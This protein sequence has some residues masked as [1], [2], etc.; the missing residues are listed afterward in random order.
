V[1]VGVAGAVSKLDTQF[2][3]GFAKGRARM[4]RQEIEDHI[5]EITEQ[6]KGSMPDAARQLLYLDRKDLRAKLAEIEAYA[7]DG[8]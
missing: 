1:A 6:M 3:P 8:V 7:K 2:I 5:A 4:T